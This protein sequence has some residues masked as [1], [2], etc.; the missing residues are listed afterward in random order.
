[1]CDYLNKQ[2]ET[3]Y[4]KA[5]PQVLAKHLM[6]GRVERPLIKGKSEGE[7]LEYI[8]TSLKTREP[9]YSK[10]KH[11]LD[12]NL[13]DNHSKIQESVK[14]MCRLLDLPYTT[15]PKNKTSK[16]PY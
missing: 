7:L 13:L 3:V 6:M 2:G 8:Q 14:L 9:F 16:Y 15:E 5:T 1:M 10:A 11:T 12:V 4:L